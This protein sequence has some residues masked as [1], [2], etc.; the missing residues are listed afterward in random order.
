MSERGKRWKNMGRYGSVG[1]ELIIS[2]LLGFYGG[3]WLDQRFGGGKGW[4]TLLGFVV[5]VYAGFRQLFRVGQ[6]MNRDAEREEREERA[7]RVASDEES[8][9]TGRKHDE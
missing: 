8:S 3:R 6:Q 5:G 2:M 7:R 9:R 1:I 4:L